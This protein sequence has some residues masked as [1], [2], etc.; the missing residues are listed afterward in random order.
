MVYTV[1]ELRQIIKKK[2]KKYNIAAVYIF[3]SYARGDATDSSDVD[4]LFRRKGSAVRGIV[5]GALYEELR[6]AMGKG[7]DLVTEESLVQHNTETRNAWFYENILRERVQIY[8]Q[9]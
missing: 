6:E 4:V 1:E 2:K 9:S 8:D 7:I 3:G 5:I